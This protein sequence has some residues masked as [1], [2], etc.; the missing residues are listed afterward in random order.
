[1]TKEPWLVSLCVLSCLLLTRDL[2][3]NA[4]RGERLAP[5]SVKFGRQTECGAVV[6][7]PV[8]ESC[9][10]SCPPTPRPSR[11]AAHQLQETACPESSCSCFSLLVDSSD[12][13]WLWEFLLPRVLHLPH[14]TFRP[15]RETLQLVRCHH[16]L[17]QRL[18]T[19]FSLDLRAHGS[20]ILVSRLLSVVHSVGFCELHFSIQI[21]FKNVAFG[22]NWNKLILSTPAHQFL[23]VISHYLTN[24]AVNRDHV[25][26]V[27]SQVEIESSH[28]SNFLQH[29]TTPCVHRQQM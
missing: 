4:K 22:T 17:V 27:M 19:E 8:I 11:Q 5:H 24:F 15:L 10:R 6:R 29:N 3:V 13:F 26:T 7:H 28:A 18:D 12:S 2:S 21:E 9:N 25:S 1:M 14:F 23:E 16:Q 20:A